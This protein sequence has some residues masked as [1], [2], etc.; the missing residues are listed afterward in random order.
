MNLS[1]A[2]ERMT[3]KFEGRATLDEADRRA[4]Y[5][6]PFRVKA[7]EPGQYLVREGS[8]PQESS[9]ILSGLA[10]RCKVTA[11]GGRQIVSIHVPGDFIDLEGSFLKIADHNVQALTRGE[12]ATVPIEAI[13]GL[14][15][16]R[17][18]VGRA[19]WI[20]TLVDG[21]LYREWVMNVGRR[22]ARQRIGHILCEFARRLET[23]GSAT[24]A[25]TISR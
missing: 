12:I 19:M 6:L 16:A 22:S 23:A 24:P 2:L 14:V 3:R 25:A 8:S 15:D 13:I 10:Y 4:L 18:R 20:E 9:L 21:S 7:Y 5:A 11:D 17:P 1:A